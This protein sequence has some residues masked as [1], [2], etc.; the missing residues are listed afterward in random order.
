MPT[1]SMRSDELRKQTNKQT[2]YTWHRF[3][4]IIK[5]VLLL[6]HVGDGLKGVLSFCCCIYKKKST[7]RKHKTDPGVVFAE[8][9]PGSMECL[10][11]KLFT[12]LSNLRLTNVTVPN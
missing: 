9:K 2:N 7:K 4:S 1:N 5:N 8:R 11:T 12:R 10:T 3:F 6:L